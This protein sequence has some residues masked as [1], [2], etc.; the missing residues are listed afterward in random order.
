MDEFTKHYLN[1]ALWSSNDESGSPLDADYSLEDISEE[2]KK[3]AIEDCDLFREKAGDLLDE[4]E[5]TQVAHDFWLTRNHHGAGFWDGDYDTEIGEKLTAISKEFKEI[6]L[7]V[8]DD[9]QIY[10]G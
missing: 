1:T 6:N 3:Q 10:H 8:G 7:Y 5:E 9:N 2:T 4:L